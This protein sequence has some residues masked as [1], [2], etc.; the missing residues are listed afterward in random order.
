MISFPYSFWEPVNGPTTRA[1][2]F[3]FLHFQGLVSPPSSHDLYFDEA[4]LAKHRG[5]PYYN[6]YM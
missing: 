4:L 3:P 2:H 5:R 1:L 6:R